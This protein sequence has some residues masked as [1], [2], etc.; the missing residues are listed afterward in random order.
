MSEAQESV[1]S[2]DPTG[3]QPVAELGELQKEVERLRAHNQQLAA[4]QSRY[5][6]ER[7]LAEEIAAK[8]REQAKKAEVRGQQLNPDQEQRLERFDALQSR[9][10]ELETQL[11]QREE[12]MR[13]E[14]LRSAAISAFNKHGAKNGEHLY[15]LR[16]NDLVLGDDGTVRALDG[17]VERDLDSYASSLK[18]ES[19]QLAY[20]FESSGARGMSSV[21]SSP[22]AVSGSENPYVTGRFDKIVEL[23]VSDPELAARMK[24][25]AGK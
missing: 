10:S 17:G 14:R 13:K 23:E 22:A 18:S 9:V 4:E 19:S 20:L 6:E 21:G 15:E 25:Q 11:R 3:Q 5:R 7:R 1:G 2:V 16:K 12:A 24:A 8:A